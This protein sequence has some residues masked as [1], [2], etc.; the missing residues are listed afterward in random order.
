MYENI[1]LY[2]QGDR[3][4]LHQQ[5]EL[6]RTSALIGR[7]VRLLGHEFPLPSGL[8]GSEFESRSW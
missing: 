6:D 3:V 5:N 8:D 1:S 7:L 4:N 2:K